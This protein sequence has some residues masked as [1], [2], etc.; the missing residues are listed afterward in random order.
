MILKNAGDVDILFDTRLVRQTIRIKMQGFADIFSRCSRCCFFIFYEMKQRV[1]YFIYMVIY[2]IVSVYS[3]AE[4]NVIIASMLNFIYIETYVCLNV[5][6][7][8]II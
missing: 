7:S 8:K 1:L 6:A 5:F 3:C 2:R 4:F